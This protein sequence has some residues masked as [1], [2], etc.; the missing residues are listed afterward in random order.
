MRATL[1]LSRSDFPLNIDGLN[2]AQLTLFAVGLRSATSEL[3]ILSTQHTTGGQ[4]VDAGQVETSGGIAGT[5]RPGGAPWQPLLGTDPAGTWELQ[6]ED[7]PPV[8]ALFTS[9]T[10]QDVVLAMSV[11]GTTQPW[12]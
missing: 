9:G 3:T 7:T 11:A 6:F 2:L 5:R 10:V 4:T 8:R 12:P 1:S